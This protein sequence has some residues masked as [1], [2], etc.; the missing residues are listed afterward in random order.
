MILISLDWVADILRIDNLTKVIMETLIIG[1]GL[2]RDQIAKK[3]ICFGANNITKHICD[4]Y[5]FHFIKVHCMAH[6]INLAMQTL[7]KLPLMS[8][9]ENLLQTLHSYFAHS[10]KR[11]LNFIKLEKFMCIRQNKILQNVKTRW[12]SMFNPIKKMI[13]QYKT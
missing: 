5:V 12:I 11:H 8:H 7:S 9:L 1:G 13:A 3:F 4:S 6:C 10:P 2:W